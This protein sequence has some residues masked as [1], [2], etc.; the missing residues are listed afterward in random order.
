[1]ADEI[2]IIFVKRSHRV[3]V[4]MDKLTWGDALRLKERREQ[5]QRG[6]MSDAE[7]NAVLTELVQKVTGQDPGALPATVVTRVIDAIV[8]AMS[9]GP[10]PNSAG[11]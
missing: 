4:D 3:E 5:A 7:A 8:E 2:E 6:E 10:D 11:G 9:D 1:M